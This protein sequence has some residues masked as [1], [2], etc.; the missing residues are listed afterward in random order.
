MN[1]LASPKNPQ[2]CMEQVFEYLTGMGWNG[3][4]SDTAVAPMESLRATFFTRPQ[5]LVLLCYLQIIRE[6][7]PALQ[8]KVEQCC[9]TIGYKME[10]IHACQ[11]WAGPVAEKLARYPLELIFRQ[12][13]S[14]LQ[15][16]IVQWVARRWG[17]AGQQPIR[18]A[19]LQADEFRYPGESGLLTTLL[20]AIPTLRW[21]LSLVSRV[22]TS[23]SQTLDMPQIRLNSL[24]V[25]MRNIPHIARC[26]EKAREALAVSAPISLYLSPNRSTMVMLGIS[27]PVVLLPT[28]MASTFD[29]DE[30][31]FLLGREL[32]KILCNHQQLL[33]LLETFEGAADQASLGILAQLAT[34]LT[35][36][37]W[38]RAAQLSC[39]RAGLLACQSTEVAERVFLKCMG[40]PI[41]YS[42][43]IPAWT[44]RELV[45][46][47]AEFCDQSSFTSTVD[48]ALA[49]TGTITGPNLPLLTRASILYQWLDSGEFAEVMT[50]SKGY[51]ASEELQ[52]ILKPSTKGHY[53][54][55]LLLAAMMKPKKK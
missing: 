22:G 53:T 42:R 12:P 54:D 38:R 1:A 28:A 9:D 6:K 8:H 23:V 18:L 25:T 55:D 29:Q 14:G 2:K 30:L 40:Y 24:E 26:W 33:G 32:G 45:A 16:D 27:S 36:D 46:E 49:W 21:Q 15:H 51:S 31:V 10:D 37:K 5:S 20:D 3:G 47:R 44:L 19:G 39:D 43:Q 50:R 7:F 13:P 11:Q 52:D 35:F 41:R 34:N 48:Q 17:T 4:A